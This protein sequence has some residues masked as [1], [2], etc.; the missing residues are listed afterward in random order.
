MDARDPWRGVPLG[1]RKKAT[2]FLR[3]R[4]KRKRIKGQS[5]YPR[6]YSVPCDL[7][8]KDGSGRW[9]SLGTFQTEDEALDMLEL[10][11]WIMNIIEMRRGALD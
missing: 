5:S 8:K 2:N 1:P 10:E 6:E 3:V 11:V 7:Q 9:V 4:I